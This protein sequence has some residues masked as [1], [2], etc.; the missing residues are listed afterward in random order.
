MSDAPTVQVIIVNWNHGRYLK[1]CLEGLYR[2]SYPAFHITVWDNASTDGSPE[3][4]RENAPQVRLV[5]A[6]RNLGFSTALNQAMALERDPLVLS[7]NPDVTARPAFLAGLVE[8]L[9]PDSRIGMAA[10]RLLMA[11]RPDCLDSTGLF[12]N[13]RRLPYDRGQGEPDR[14]QYDSQPD[15]FGA[16]GAAALYRRA[17]LEDVAMDGETF[18][19]DFFAYYEDADLAWRAQLRGWRA[20]YAPAAVAEH[21]RGSGD[22]LRNAKTP[23]GNGPRY[24]F[25]NRALMVVKNDQGR[26][27]VADLPRMLAADLPRLGYMLLARPQALQSIPDILRLLPR[28]LKKRRLIQAGCR[29]DPRAIYRRYICTPHNLSG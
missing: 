27:L 3:W 25:R 2:Q 4:L 24:A 13:R 8:C 21:V 6:P 11:G 29:V 23:G 28:M 20:A 12:I 14:G 22:R 18:D 15:V 9:Q 17:M 7:L 16:C 19:E 1:T 10:P 26:S 5:C